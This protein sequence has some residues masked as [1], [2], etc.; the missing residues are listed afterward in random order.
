MQKNQQ[1]KEDN[2][3]FEE[4]TKKEYEYFC[5]NCMFSELQE[6]ILKDRIKDISIIAI[7]LKYNISESKVNKE[8]RKIKDKIIKVI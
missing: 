2:L 5:E 7:S 1:K 3:R 6:K 4:F 8:V